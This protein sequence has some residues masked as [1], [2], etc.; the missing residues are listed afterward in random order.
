MSS[1][2][3][4]II[5]VTFNA[6]NTVER[7]IKSVDSQTFDD[8]E[9]LII[10]G[11]SSDD[12]LAIVENLGKKANR[13]VLSEPDNGIYDAMNKGI[14]MA[15][16][17]YLVF[18]NSGDKFHS[19]D[20][21]SLIAET[22]EKNDS[23]GIVYGQTDLVDDYGTF[24]APRHLSAPETLVLS[25]FAKGMVVC[26]QAFVAKRSIAPYFSLKYRYSA[27]YEW[28]IICLMHSK[29]NVY[30]DS[31]LIDYLIEGASTANRK[32]S[33]KERFNIMSTYYGF[34]PTV[35]RHIGFV[36][37]YF[38]HKRQLKKAGYK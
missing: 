20:T 34:W 26:H 36:G 1:P 31:V 10:D 29:K 11:A 30:I 21:L 6:S 4:S 27:D 18:L 37:R 25:D 15:R 19:K 38:R 14:G 22:I 28:C 5:T 2:L 12:T 35:W 16:G 7:T 3:F 17:K 8:F 9:H 13:I 32:D 33:L 23:P 24:V